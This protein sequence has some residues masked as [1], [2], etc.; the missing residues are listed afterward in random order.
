MDL[1]KII[2]LL[3]PILIAEGKKIVDEVL[4]PELQKIVKEK[5]ENPI[6]EGLALQLLEVMKKAADAELEAL[7]K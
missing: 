5:I 3:K 2:E 7:L 6:Y 4:Y 1:S